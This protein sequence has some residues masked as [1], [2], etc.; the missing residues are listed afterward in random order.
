MNSLIN[1]IKARFFNAGSANDN[2]ELQ[3]LKS[4]NAAAKVLTPRAPRAQYSDFLQSPVRSL[5]DTACRSIKAILVST[6]AST[7]GRAVAKGI[8]VVESAL[9]SVHAGKSDSVSVK[10]SSPSRAS[11]P[12]GESVALDKVF[13]AMER[14]D[15]KETI[16]AL[17]EMQQLVGDDE[18]KL[19]T[20]VET[21]LHE[22]GKNQINA[23]SMVHQFVSS[24][25]WKGKEEEH[26]NAGDQV[27]QFYAKFCQRFE[28]GWTA[29]RR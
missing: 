26:D 11:S 4:E 12:S 3:D 19:N 6:R 29:M 23:F 5:V 28:A 8:A 16:N 2:F 20:L 18:E 27:R 10:R 1:S 25:P 9:S 7:L 24:D 22:L 14:N 17:K 13:N 21:R 15:P